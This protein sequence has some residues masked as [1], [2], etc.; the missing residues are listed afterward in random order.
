MTQRHSARERAGHLVNVRNGGVLLAASAAAVAAWQEYEHRKVLRADLTEA[1]IRVERLSDLRD[2]NASVAA[3]ED[4]LRKEW[5]EFGLLGFES[6]AALAKEAG[7]TIFI[8]SMVVDGVKT[9]LGALQTILVDC[10]GDPELLRDEFANFAELTEQKA[11][12]RSR[13][14]GGDTAVLLQITVFAKGGRGGGLGSTLR[15]AVLHM[16]PEDVNFAIT[17][18]PADGSVID[19]A[20]RKT[21]NPAMRFHAKGGATPTI[22]LQGFKTPAEG[23]TPSPHGQDVIV[24]RYSRDEDGNWPVPRPEMRTRSIGPVQRQASYAVK[25]LGGLGKR[26][27][28]AISGLARRRRARVHV[29]DAKAWIIDHAGSLARRSRRL[30]SRDEGSQESPLDLSGSEA[31]A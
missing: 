29:S 7:Q 11:W 22:L 13:R 16:L 14:K 24:L 27:S 8:A 5:G 20:D 18:T 28:I 26:G 15:D 6:G 1:H 23:Q 31:P 12:R 30:V 9:P 3:V 19:L 2:D 4:G 21:F 17:M 25:R 10:H